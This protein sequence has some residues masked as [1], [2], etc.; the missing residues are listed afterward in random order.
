MLDVVNEVRETLLGVDAVTRLRLHG[1][2]PVLQS[3]VSNWYAT[4]P[5]TYD[6]LLL[7]AASPTSGLMMGANGWPDLNSAAAAKLK[8]SDVALS[9][10]RNLERKQPP[11]EL[12]LT[13]VGV[14]LRRAGIESHILDAAE[15]VAMGQLPLVVFLVARHAKELSMFSTVVPIAPPIV[16]LH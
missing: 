9:I 13:G 5:T 1:C 16:T 10:V 3:T 11:G 2:L 15:I 7:V 12:I 8:R 6:P 4:A 14:I